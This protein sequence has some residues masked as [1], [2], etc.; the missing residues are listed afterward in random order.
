M[1]QRSLFRSE[2]ST[3]HRQVLPDRSVREKLPDQRFPIG[4]G[5]GKQQN[6][7]CKPIGAMDY[8]SALPARLEILQQKR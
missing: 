7:G 8:Q 5:F 3:N 6:S 2:M 1:N 4:V